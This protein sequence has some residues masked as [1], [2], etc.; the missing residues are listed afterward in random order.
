MGLLTKGKLWEGLS[1]YR[2]APGMARALI[3][4]GWLAQFKVFNEIR[5]HNGTVGEKECAWARRFPPGQAQGRG[6][7]N[8]AV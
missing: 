7:R 2:K 5:L 4:S 6:G 1:D 3:S 8:P